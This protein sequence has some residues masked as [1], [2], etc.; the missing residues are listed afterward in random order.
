VSSDGRLVTI[1]GIVGRANEAALRSR[2]RNAM[3]ANASPESLAW[4]L[5][6]FDGPYCGVLDTIRPAA[7][8]MV[9]LGLRNGVTRLHKD[10]DIVPQISMPDYGAW[11]QLD[12]FSSD[13]GITHLHPTAISPAKVETARSVV[14]VGN[15][16]KE[17]WQVAAPFGTD[18]V[19]AI[20]SSTPLFPVARPEDETVADYLKALRSALDDAARRGVKVSAN[21]ILVQTT[22]P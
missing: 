8:Q 21:A 19:V 11:L 2:A 10:D 13:G 1:A 18:L 5:E 3:P 22:D 12:Y 17:R 4:R 14:V 15:T 6:L 9:S 7:G 16:I 20:V